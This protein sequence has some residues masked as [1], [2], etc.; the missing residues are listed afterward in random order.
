MKEEKELNEEML[1]EVSGGEAKG[2][3]KDYGYCPF[4]GEDRPLESGGYA[5]NV[6]IHGKWIRSVQFHICKTCGRHFY[7]PDILDRY[8]DTEGNILM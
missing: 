3:S 6:Q 2:V 1:E 4:E 7:G 8:Y 5:H